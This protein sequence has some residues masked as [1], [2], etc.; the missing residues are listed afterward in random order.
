MRFFKFGARETVI[1]PGTDNEP[2]N[3]YNFMELGDLVYYK[4]PGESRTTATVI[5]FTVDNHNRP[6]IITIRLTDGSEIE[7]PVKYISY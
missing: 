2:T 1:Q 4:P 7:T 5:T 3:F 6:D